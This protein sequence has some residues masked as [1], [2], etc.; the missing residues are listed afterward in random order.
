M[1]AWQRV[2]HSGHLRRI[3]VRLYLHNM[4]QL[5]LFICCSSHTGINVN[6][7]IIHTTHV[8]EEPQD[9]KCRHTDHLPGSVEMRL[10]TAAMYNMWVTLWFLQE[11]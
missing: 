2:D 1:E 6:I 11:W 7:I 10:N 9:R 4:E 5:L 3:T 8:G